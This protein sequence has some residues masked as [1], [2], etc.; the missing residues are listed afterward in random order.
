MDNGNRRLFQLEKLA[1]VIFFSRNGIRLYIC[2][3]KRD[4][5]VAQLAVENQN[6][7]GVLDFQGPDPKASG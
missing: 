1:S 5:A 7:A 2:S 4:G 3:P 6:D